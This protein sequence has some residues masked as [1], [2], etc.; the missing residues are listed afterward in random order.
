M[1]KFPV[2][3]NLQLAASSRENLAT[4]LERLAEHN[5]AMKQYEAE[6]KLYEFNEFVKAWAEVRM[7]L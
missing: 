3:L 5:A 7:D 1:S 6:Q 4:A 2:R